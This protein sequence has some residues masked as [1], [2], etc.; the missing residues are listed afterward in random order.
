MALPNWQELQKS[1]DDPETIEQAI[2]RLVAEHEADPEAHLGTGESL[3]NHK[4]EDIIDHPPG[5]VLAD[6]DTMTEISI[7]H[8]FSNLSVWNISGDVTNGNW[9]DVSVYVEW[10][11]QNSSYAYLTP[12]NPSPWLDYA[13][14]T[15]Y[16]VAYRTDVTGSNYHAHFGMGINDDTPTEGFGFL[17]QSGVLK[18]YIGYGGEQN[19][20]T[21]SSPDIANSHIYRAHLDPDAGTCK[22]Y[23][24]GVLVATL[25]IP[26]TSP[27]SDGGPRMGA[28]VSGTGDGISYF[29]DLHFSRSII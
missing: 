12:Q 18:A 4:A 11:A 3:Q 28:R 23:I 10:G 15:V 2:A 22:F 1:L 14:E 9:P 16:Q 6:K 5:S 8:D 24:D 19:F 21:I 7:D 25:D 29:S 26:A 27:D 13:F 20:A 17:V